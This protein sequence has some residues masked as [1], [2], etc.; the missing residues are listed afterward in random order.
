MTERAKCPEILAKRAIDSNSFQNF[1][2]GTIYAKEARALSISNKKGNRLENNE[3]KCIICK[4]N[5]KCTG[6][7]NSKINRVYFYLEHRDSKSV[8]KHAQCEKKLAASKVTNSRKKI[9]HANS[10]SLNYEKVVVHNLKK[11]STK[12]VIKRF[13]T[14][15]KSISSGKKKQH[16]KNHNSTTSISF[17]LSLLELW[18]DPSIDNAKQKCSINNE[19]VTLKELFVNL[20]KTVPEKNKYRVFYGD[21][22]ARIGKN[23]LLVIEPKSF[24]TNNF[25][26]VTKKGKKYNSVSTNYSFLKEPEWAPA[27]EKQ[28]GQITTWYMIGKIK[29]NNEFI[30]FNNSMYKNLYVE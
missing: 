19:Q 15:K 16:T 24:K 3:F 18:R 28:V 17:V 22:I 26:T 9:Q 8:K 11:N 25:K 21:A 5:L 14:G 7:N 12:L 13:S 6:W 30:G 4:Q 27:C 23:G 29:P 20:D 10:K 2:K 1:K